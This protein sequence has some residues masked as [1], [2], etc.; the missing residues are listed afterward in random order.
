MHFSNLGDDDL[1]D[2]LRDMTT[3]MKDEIKQIEE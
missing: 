3:S 2:I 1:D